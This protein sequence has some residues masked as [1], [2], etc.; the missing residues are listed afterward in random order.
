M[1][2]SRTIIIRPTLLCNAHCE[3][4]YVS[5]K[6]GTMPLSLVSIIIGQIHDF[7][8][9]HPS[10]NINLLWH[11]GEP[12]LMSIDFWEHVERML[13]GIIPTRLSKHVQT[14][15]LHSDNSRYLWFINHG[16]TLSSSLDGEYEIHHKG[17]NLNLQQYEL[18]KQ[19]IAKVREANGSLGVVCVVSRLHINHPIETLGFF[20]NMEIN[21]NFNMVR[22][23]NQLYKISYMEYYQFLIDMAKHWLSNSSSKI[24]VDPIE[25]DVSALFS[26]PKGICDRSDNCFESFLTIDPD[27]SVYPCNRFAPMDNWKF[28]KVQE[29]N[30]EQLWTIAS[31]EFSSKISP[32]VERCKNCRWH[33]V[34]GGGCKW[35]RWY[36]V[37][38]RNDEFCQTSSWYFKTLFDLL[39][40][41][42]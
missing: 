36:D 2:R 25:T 37:P 17:R 11:G 14:N 23:N 18:L 21:V 33:S 1:N 39:R 4:C 28:G 19:N 7:L 40:S 27:G 35:L 8:D 16:Y 13:E 22:T 9:T 38:E 26:D 24:S 29:A 20:E 30:L 41:K 15:L 12:S 31:A 10:E 32:L 3:Y 5:D 42:V 6:Q 34:C